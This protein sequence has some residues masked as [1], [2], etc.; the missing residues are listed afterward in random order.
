MNSKCID[1]IA[2][3]ETRLEHTISS[4]EVTVSG[5]VLKRKDTNRD[6]GGL[7]LYMRNTINYEHLFDLECD[8]LERIGIKVI[9]PQAKSFIV[10]T[11]YKPPRSNVDT[12]K[13]F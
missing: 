1:I 4:G 8:N 5:Y 2:V 11:W 13:D 7:S 10:S 6:G 9:K 3:N 12:M